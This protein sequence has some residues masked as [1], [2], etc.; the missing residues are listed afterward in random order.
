MEGPTDRAESPVR[1]D[2]PADIPADSPVD[3]LVDGPADIPAD[4]PADIPADIPA[5]TPAGTP[6]DILEDSPE[7]SPVHNHLDIPAESPVDSSV[8]WLP[9]IIPVDCPAS[10]IDPGNPVGGLTKGES[11]T[12]APAEAFSSSCTIGTSR[13]KLKNLSSY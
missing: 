10:V 6:A 7:D 11:P 8:N 1:G 5:D 13:S 4:G 3:I 9:I 2:G 12:A